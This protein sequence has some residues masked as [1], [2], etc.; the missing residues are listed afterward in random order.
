[1]ASMTRYLEAALQDHMLGLTAYTMPTGVFLGLHT[2]S[3]TKSGSRTYEVTT[4]G[5]GY[6]RQAITAKMGAT[7]TST[8]IAVN[9]VVITHGPAT[10]D[11]GTI[12]YASIDDAVTA[13]NMLE[14]AAPVT[15]QTVP[16]GESFQLT[17]G[18]M[19]LRFE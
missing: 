8:G 16:I 14:F 3:P 15:A 6:A 19:S 17:P 13:G 5:S 2:A 1:M 10:T 11:W 9:T 18:Q 7:N 4:S 12:T